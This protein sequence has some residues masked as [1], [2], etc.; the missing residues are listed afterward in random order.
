MKTKIYQLKKQFNLLK[1]FFGLLFFLLTSCSS[2]HSIKRKE[3]INIHKN[4]SG[5]F[6]NSNNSGNKTKL[7]FFF[8]LKDRDSI[9]EISTKKNLLIV[10]FIDELGG[11]HY[12]T[13]EGKFRRKYFQFHLIYETSL[14][15]PILLLF[16]ENRVRLSID[17]DSNLVINNY[18]DNSGMVL[19]MG[20]GNSWNSEY[21]FNKKI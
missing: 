4:I 21:T 7:S 13:F 3:L 2:V 8:D 5:S 9:T 15:P 19:I 10:A 11:K 12:K 14:Y 20:A 6:M 18:H 17:K 16:Q 1:I